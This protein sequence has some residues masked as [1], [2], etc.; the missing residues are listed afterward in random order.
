LINIC[1]AGLEGDH[2][3]QAGRGAMDLCLWQLAPQRFDHGVATTPVT[4]PHQP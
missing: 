1:A 2:E 4:S 3:M